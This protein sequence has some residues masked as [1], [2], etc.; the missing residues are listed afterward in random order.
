MKD[1]MILGCNSGPVTSL[2]VREI[3]GA[4]LL[5]CLVRSHLENHI[6]FWVP[7]W[8]GTTVIEK[9]ESGK[10]WGEKTSPRS[11]TA[12]FLHLANTP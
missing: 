3:R 7:G 10:V 2:R 11:M 9:L 12:I 6:Y 8:K 5:L 1:N 4:L